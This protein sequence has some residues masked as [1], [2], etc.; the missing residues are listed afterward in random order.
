LAMCNVDSMQKR[1]DNLKKQIKDNEKK[2]EEK[3]KKFSEIRTKL[4]ELDSKK[5][6]IGNQISD[7]ES[8]LVED[9]N[10]TCDEEQVEKVLQNELNIINNRLREANAENK[11]L[12]NYYE[13]L[14]AENKDLKSRSKELFTTDLDTLEKVALKEDEI[15]NFEHADMSLENLQLLAEELKREF[16]QMDVPN[17]RY[18]KEFKE[19]DK[20]YRQKLGVIENH[21]KIESEQR[22][23]RNKLRDL[24]YS[25][26]N[27]SFSTVNKHLKKLYNL[28]TMGGI[29]E[30]EYV[31]NLSPF[32]QG[33]QLTVM[34]PQKSWKAVANLSG[35]E[36]TLS[37]LSL[38]F[39]LHSL[40]PSPFY[41]M[42]EIDAALDYRNVSIISEYITKQ[43]KRFTQ[44]MVI[45]LREQMFINADIFIAIYKVNEQTKSVAIVNPDKKLVLP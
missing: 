5:I 39:A 45:S 17:L 43:S 32:E 19:K 29:A 23:Y 16:K 3:S 6:N 41:V 15:E 35:G 8:Q 14:N 1:S 10:K 37:S 25:C 27:K 9:Q 36:K 26:F 31:D 11:S 4:D 7:T 42:D 40:R 2:L 30:L 24:R 34:P 22:E 13:A 33:I 20:I 21:D 38:V 18:I 44:F 12:Y 28:I